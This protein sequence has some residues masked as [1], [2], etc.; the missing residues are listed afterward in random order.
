MYYFGRNN[1]GR[2]EADYHKTMFK[3]IHFWKNTRDRI[4]LLYSIIIRISFSFS[5]IFGFFGWDKKTVPT[6]FFLNLKLRISPYL[7]FTS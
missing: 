4:V 3:H 7:L 2:S 6:A 1:S 5:V